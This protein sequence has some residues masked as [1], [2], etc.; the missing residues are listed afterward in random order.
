MNA[1]NSLLRMVSAQQADELRLGVG[2]TPL[3]LAQGVP[4]NLTL[5]ETGDRVL[6]Q[7][8]GS[9]FSAEAEACLGRGAA[10]DATYDAGDALGVYWVQFQ[11]RSG[12]E[13]GFDVTLTN[14][15][16][17]PPEVSEPSG[18]SEVLTEAPRVR[19]PRPT[20]ALETLFAEAVR[21]RASDVHVREGEPAFAR[22]DGRVVR[23]KDGPF[24][25]RELIGEALVAHTPSVDV[26]LT[27]SSAGRVRLHA[28]RVGGL[29]AIAARVLP[30]VVPALSTLGF[31]VSLADLAALPSG[32]VL[33]TGPTG[34]GKST[35][36]ASL[37]Q[38]VLRQRSAVLLTLEDPIEYCF[39]TS[40]TRSIVRQRQ[41]GTDVVDFSTGLRDA[42]REDPDLLL[43]GEMRDAESIS[44]ALTAAE[45]GHLVF[46]SL[47]SRSAASAIERIVDTYPA[48][49]Q[50]QLRV[51][52]SE[53]LRAI[54]AQRLL[55]RAQGSGRVVALE[56]LRRNSAVANLIREGK[57]P[58]LVNVL[59]S[60]RK[61]GMLQLERSLADLC[62][63]GVIDEEDARGAANDQEAL[64]EY[65][66]ARGK[67]S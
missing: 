12:Q 20:P 10:F 48:A 29:T 46:A 42:L 26:S 49:R 44:L 54:I 5:A 51:Q 50:H 2:R 24:D 55:P 39:D 18:P 37:C 15:P 14:A 64:S 9:L 62:R 27:S 66:H 60:S 65:L 13:G 61:E 11:P 22:V 16:A 59:Q 35:T 40:S 21:L 47:H 17:A 56:V 19:S 38:E 1:L 43:V 30:P 36:A 31:P 6:R 63:S 33:V 41:I 52:L 25:M 8:L 53:S 3:V 28:F 67:A 7:M 34:S 32:L 58:Q 57:T 23:L 45:T 4:K